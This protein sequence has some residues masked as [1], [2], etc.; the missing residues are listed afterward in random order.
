MGTLGAKIKRGLLFAGDIFV[1]YLS[2]W[3]SLYLRSGF[4]AGYL[5]LEQ[6]A[7]HFVPFTIIYFV[8]LMIFYIIGLYDL[9]I[10]RNNLNF[11][12]TLIKALLINIG[13]SVAF[14]Y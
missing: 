14:F 3:F 9:H 12:S 7:Q 10:A 2:L 11:F 13:I 1:L 5:K 8:W 4:N 6:T